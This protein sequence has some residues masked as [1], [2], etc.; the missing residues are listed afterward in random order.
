MVRRGPGIAICAA[1]GALPDQ[2]HAAD[3]LRRVRET[4]AS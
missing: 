1:F 4:H 3:A 2:R